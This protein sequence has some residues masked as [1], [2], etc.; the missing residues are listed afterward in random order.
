MINELAEKYQMTTGDPY[1]IQ[2]YIETIEQDLRNTI[3]LNEEN[4]NL[5]VEDVMYGKIDPALDYL[6]ENLGSSL[7]GYEDFM[8]AV[9]YR[10]DELNYMTRADFQTNMSVMLN[11]G[12]QD[13][14]YYPYMNWK[15]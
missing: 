12:G 14:A 3:Q 13:F 2:D 15:N 9:Q 7:D 6:S 4:G 10:I 5:S 1:Y 11:Y 8:E